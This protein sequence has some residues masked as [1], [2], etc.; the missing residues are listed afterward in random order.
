VVDHQ[1]GEF[2]AVD[3]DDA[4]IVFRGGG[5]SLFGEGRRCDEDAFFRAVFGERAGKFLNLGP[6]D[7]V[8]PALGLQVNAIEAQAV[9]IDDAV[10]TA[11]SAA[12][13]RPA[14]ILT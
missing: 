5:K 11:I 12:A 10:D 13:N 6:T 7:G 2:F 1:G 4:G 9:F 14:S 8:F 3:Q